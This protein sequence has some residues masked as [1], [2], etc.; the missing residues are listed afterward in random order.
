MQTIYEKYMQTIYEKYMQTI[1]ADWILVLVTMSV[2][3]FLVY[4]NTIKY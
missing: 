3:G 2:F 1:Y 4:M